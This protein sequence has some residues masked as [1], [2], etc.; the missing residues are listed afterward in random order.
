MIITIGTTSDDKRV[1]HKL[2]NGTDITVQLKQPCNILNPIFIIGYDS[3]L[4]SAN[5]LYF[6]EFNR[7]YFIDN[8]NLMPGHRMELQ[9]SVDVLMSYANQIDGLKC[10]VSRQQNSGLTL[11][12]DS[13]IM[14]QNYN[15]IDVYN[16]SQ[17]FD[18]SIGSY[19]LQVIG[20]N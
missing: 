19:I 12:P 10:V 14:V 6:S 1:L 17:V 5:Y 13:G 16:F 2:W 9:C 18:I 11:V 8:I 7:Y 4:V 3:S 20:G 15:P